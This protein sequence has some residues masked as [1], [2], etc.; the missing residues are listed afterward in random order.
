MKIITKYLLKEI[1]TPFG[2]TLTVFTLI[3]I[4]GNLMQL[5]EM[6]VQ[7]GVGV[8]NIVRLLGYTLPFLM[9]YIIPM[10]FFVSILLG[11]LRLASDNEVTALKGSGLSFFQLLPPVLILS[12]SGTILTGFAAMVA[13]PWGERSLKN[14][15]FQVAVV[16]AKVNLKERVFY[17]EFKELVFYIQKVHGD[18]LLEDVFIYDQREKDLPQTIVAKRGWLIPN[19]KERSLNLRLEDGHIYNVSLNSKS[20]QT[21]FFKSYDLFLPLEEIV[22]N[23]EKR[24]KSETEMYLPELK[25]RIRQTSPSEKK[26]YNYQIEYYKKFSLPFAC[27]VLGLIAFPL[28]LQS[29]MAGRPWAVVLGG[30]VFFIYYL[31]LS[32]A[33]SLG[34]R[35]A[36]PPIIG[37][38][39]PN[40]IVGLVGIYLFRLAYLE[41]ELTWL[42][43]LKQ[44]AAWLKE[45][46]KKSKPNI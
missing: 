26:Y 24:E 29:R 5:I 6:I 44:A 16:Q 22:S 14:L 27:L 25:E 34:E 36:L 32:L 3:F 15:L 2:I 41:K 9:V 1:L 23:Q 30:T 17:N 45:K 7:K 19:P 8:F 38:W 31:F 20:A 40:I 13:Q 28:G 12:L 4:L 35:G 46:V 18:G 11:F 39:L 42:I 43:R 21:V 37:L 10:S 33:F